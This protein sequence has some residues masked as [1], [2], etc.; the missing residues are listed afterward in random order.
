M[1]LCSRNHDQCRKLFF[2]PFLLVCEKSF[3]VKRRRRFISINISDSSF[4]SIMIIPTHASCHHPY[5]NMYRLLATTVAKKQT[6][7]YCAGHQSCNNVMKKEHSSLLLITSLSPS[8]IL[9]FY[10]L[11]K[12]I[13]IGNKKQQR[14][15]TLALA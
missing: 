13:Y 1:F 6:I 14:K 5:Q 15:D 4:S 9:L 7:G 2:S 8:S 12:I 11:F 3:F 10:L